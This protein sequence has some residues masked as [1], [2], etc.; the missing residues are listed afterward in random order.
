MDRMDALSKGIWL[1]VVSAT[2]LVIGSPIFFVIHLGLVILVGL[3][4]GRVP[5]G[6]FVRGASVLLLLALALFIFQVLFI[7]RGDLVLQIGPVPIYTSGI[8]QGLTTALRILAVSVAGLV[9]V[10]TTNPRDLILGLVHIGL[11]YRLAYAMFVAFQVVPLLRQEATIIREAHLVRGVVEESGRLEAWKRYFVPLLAFS[12]RKAEIAAIAMDS[13]AFGAYPKRTSVDEFHW[14]RSG[15]WLVG[16]FAAL[17]G[18]LI[19]AAAFTG[20]L[21]ERYSAGML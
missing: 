5:V 10:W 2:A 17:E 12:I 16:V 15:L 13:R 8:R 19:A 9:F 1:V 20:G 14:S 11:P 21:L 4:L 18:S 6:T 7:H 3:S